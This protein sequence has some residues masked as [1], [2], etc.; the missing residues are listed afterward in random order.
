MTTNAVNQFFAL[1]DK[2]G[3][4]LPLVKE[5][6]G[7]SAATVW[8]LVRQGKITAIKISA[9]VTLFN[10]GTV[11]ALLNPENKQK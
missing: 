6:L 2:A 8:R 10:V 4:R 9:G 11:R 7:C 5:V 1:P 3:A